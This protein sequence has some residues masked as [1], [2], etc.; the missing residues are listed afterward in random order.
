MAT[1]K[2]IQEHV[3]ARHGFLPRPTWIAHILNDHGLFHRIA[4]DGP[5]PPHRGDPCPLEHRDAIEDALREFDILSRA[6]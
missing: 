5:H 6:N 4:H 2:D 1:Y 3:R